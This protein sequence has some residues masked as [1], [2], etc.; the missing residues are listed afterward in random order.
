MGVDLS[1]ITPAL[2]IGAS[3]RDEHALELARDHGVAAVIDLRD[4]ACDD[5]RVL[6]RHGIELLHL[7]TVDLGAI[8]PARVVDGVGFA[9][10]HLDANRRVLIHCACGIG[11]SATLALCVLV[12]R[13]LAPLEAL[14][15]AKARRAVVSPSPAQYETWAAWLRVERDARSRTWEV[16]DF[17]AFAAI[18]YRHLG[19]R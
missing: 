14:E 2:A 11:R 1:W 8:A 5:E 13:G 3:F 9:R 6:R 12:D 16:P 4:E 18:A 15:L 10:R 17:D 7:P 19:G